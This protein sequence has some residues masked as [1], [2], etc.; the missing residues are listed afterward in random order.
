MEEKQEQTT[1]EASNR[2]HDRDKKASERRNKQFGS[3][4]LAFP[5]IL[6]FSFTIYTIHIL[7]HALDHDIARGRRRVFRPL[8][9]PFPPHLL[10][11]LLSIPPHEHDRGQPRR[12]P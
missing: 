2:G 12:Q 1:T 9:F 10:P 4:S 5:M 3:P 7:D 6:L 8:L 11:L